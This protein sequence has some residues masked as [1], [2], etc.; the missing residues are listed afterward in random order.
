[1]KPLI[2]A[3]NSV[4]RY[5][6]E[7]EDYIA[8]HNWFDSTKSAYADTR[9]RAVLHHTFGIFLCEQLFG[10]YL[11]NSAGKKISVRSV[12]E[13]HVMEDCAGKIPTVEDWM[14]TIEPEAWMRGQG[15]RAFM[16]SQRLMGAD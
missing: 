4:K 15:Q 8:I 13:D 12:A 2:H 16:E 11:E 9:H 6:G 5:G 1:M 10:V 3:Q 7:I 14:K